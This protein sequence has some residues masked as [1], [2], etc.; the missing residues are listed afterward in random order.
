M[1]QIVLVIHVFIAIGLI[2]LVLMQ[3]SEGGGTGFGGS[4]GS[5]MGFLSSRSK[6]TL[7]TRMTG[8]LAAAFICTSLGLAVLAARTDHDTASRIDKLMEEQQT[9][10]ESPSLPSVP[11]GE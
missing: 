4:S 2:S 8:Y 7:L 1:E 9:Q 10:P 5:M 6:A 3:K 11:V